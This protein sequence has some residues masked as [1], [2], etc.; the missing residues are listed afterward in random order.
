M[1]DAQI[2][3]LSVFIVIVIVFISN[4]FIDFEGYMTAL[5]I[6]ILTCIVI[7]FIVFSLSGICS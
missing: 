5:Y 3:L 6:F 1:N 7:F 2:F 4:F